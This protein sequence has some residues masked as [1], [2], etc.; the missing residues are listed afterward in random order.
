MA[1]R[2]DADEGSKI[3]KQED[4]TGMRRLYKRKAMAG[5]S[6]VEKSRIGGGLENVRGQ[7]FNK[8]KGG[9]TTSF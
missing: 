8:W 1:C 3:L 9:E 7:K 2:A 5:R 4:I 6:M